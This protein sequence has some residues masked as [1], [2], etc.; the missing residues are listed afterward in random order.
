VF[1]IRPDVSKTCGKTC[2]ERA[3]RIAD[4]NGD[5]DDELAVLRAELE[6]VTGAP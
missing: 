1:E 5:D 2:Y 6:A 3:L 4:Q